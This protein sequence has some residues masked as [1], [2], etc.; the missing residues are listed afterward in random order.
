M[1]ARRRSLFSM[2]MSATVGGVVG[3]SAVPTA[4]GGDV[5]RAGRVHAQRVAVHATGAGDGTVALLSLNWFLLG[6]LTSPMLQG[7]ARAVVPRA[8]RALGTVLMRFAAAAPV[9][10]PIAT[11]AVSSFFPSRRR[12]R[13]NCEG[14]ATAIAV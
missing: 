14:C 5:R 4:A 12:R 8:G 3:G 9:S 13:H 10:A 6:M 7:V 1:V 2:A 11:A